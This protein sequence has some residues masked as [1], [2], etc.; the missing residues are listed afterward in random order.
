MKLTAFCFGVK[1][2]RL[3]LILLSDFL[4]GAFKSIAHEAKRAEWAIA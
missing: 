1:Q 2:V 4:R 3:V